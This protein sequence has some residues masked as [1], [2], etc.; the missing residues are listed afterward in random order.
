MAALDSTSAYI[1]LMHLKVMHPERADHLQDIAD[2]IRNCGND[3]TMLVMDLRQSQFQCEE[4]RK[5][6]DNTFCEKV[7]RF[8]KPSIRRDIA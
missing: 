5:R 2:C 6:F 7:K 8:F 1:A 4:M 3:R